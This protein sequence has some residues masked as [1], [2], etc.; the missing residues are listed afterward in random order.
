MHINSDGINLIRN[1]EGCRYIAYDDLQPNVTI[2][3]ISQVKGTLTIGYGH[4]SGV[5]VGQAISLTQAI[6][7]LRSDLVIYEKEVTRIVKLP[8]NENQFSALVSFTYNCGAGNLKTLA[9]NRSLTQ[10]ADALLLYNKSKGKVLEGLKRRRKAER[11]LFLKPV[12]D[13]KKSNEEIAK[14][15]IA[16]K[17]GN[18]QERKDRLTKAGYDYQA[19]QNIVNSLLVNKNLTVDKVLSVAKA[20]IGVKESPAGSNKVKYNTEYYGRA[21]SGASYPWCCVFVWWVFKHAGAS[22]LFCHGK[23]TA[24]CEYVKSDMKAQTVKEPKAGDLILFQFDVDPQADH[25]GIVE[26]VNSDGSIVT[27]EG[28]TSS[29]NDSNGGAVM[30]RRRKKSVVMCFIRPKYD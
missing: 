5:K 20:E 8:L 26:S 19:I 25:I 28:N 11:E 21:V 18:A 23:K 29:G 12:A 6:N 14:E 17:W 2:T 7:M 13:A 27:I 1:F 30:R 24:L 16:G 4:I 9:A 10:I 3:N 22:N 15:V